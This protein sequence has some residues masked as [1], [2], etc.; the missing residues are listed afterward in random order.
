MKCSTYST[1]DHSKSSFRASSSLP[2]RRSI[3]S[4]RGARPIQRSSRPR[5]PQRV[6]EPLLDVAE[7]SPA[8]QVAGRQLA[9]LLLAQ[10]VVIPELNAGAVVEGHEQ[11]GRRGGI[12]RNP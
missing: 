8:F 6:A 5:G 4:R 7:G 12:Q 9:D 2:S 10:G 11:A 3:S 1:I